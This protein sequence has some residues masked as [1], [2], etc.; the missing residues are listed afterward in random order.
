M[1]RFH[2]LMRLLQTPPTDPVL[3]RNYEQLFSL[4]REAGEQDLANADAATFD[5]WD[6]QVRFLLSGLDLEYYLAP[7]PNLTRSPYPETRISRLSEI[8]LLRQGHDPDDL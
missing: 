6:K 7:L 8:L 4:W 2:R 1:R 5:R 3:A